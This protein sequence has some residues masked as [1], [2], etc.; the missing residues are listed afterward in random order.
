MSDGVIATDAAGRVKYLNPV[1]ERLIA[2]TLDEAA[3]LPIERVYRLRTEDD[4]PMAMCQLQRV[5][6][7]GE[8]IGRQRFILTTRK[9]HQVTVEDS[10]S[11]ILNARG[12]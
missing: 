10:A 6:N 4:Q 2:W 3:G 1:A 7:S 5:L 8:P 11:P 9:G 12:S